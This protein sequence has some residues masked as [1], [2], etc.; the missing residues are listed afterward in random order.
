[1]IEACPRNVESAFT[2]TP[3]AIITLAQLWRA[4]CSPIGSSFAVFHA[5]LAEDQGTLVDS[6]GQQLH[7]VGERL[8]Q[9][10]GEVGGAGGPDELGEGGRGGGVDGHACE[11]H[12]SESRHQGRRFTRPQLGRPGGY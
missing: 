10:V 7:V 2:L 6:E 1:M 4:G 3:A 9:P 11:N 12:K 5:A 8:L